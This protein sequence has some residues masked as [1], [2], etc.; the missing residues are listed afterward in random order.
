MGRRFPVGS[1]LLEW[2]QCCLSPRH[3]RGLPSRWLDM[4]CN[5]TRETGGRGRESESEGESQTGKRDRETERQRDRGRESFRLA[6]ERGKREGERASSAAPARTG[7]SL[8]VCQAM[9]SAMTMTAI[10]MAAYL[11]AQHT[12]PTSARLIA[13]QTQSQKAV[14]L[15]PADAITREPAFGHRRAHVSACHR[16]ADAKKKVSAGAWHSSGQRWTTQPHT[17][18]R[19][20]TEQIHTLEPPATYGITGHANR[21][22][23][24]GGY[25]RPLV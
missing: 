19:A 8:R 20:I 17:P 22:D 18:T 7:W 16:S 23:R 15:W 11:P 1:A 9:K 21:G 10:S 2:S 24:T 6:R 14:S 3:R 5:G 12:H 4:R 13:R 25:L